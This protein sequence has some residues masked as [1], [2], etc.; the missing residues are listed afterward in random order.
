MMEISSKPS[1]MRTFSFGKYNGKTVEE[2]AKIDPSYLKWFLDTK[3]KD[4]GDD[5]DW[6]Y[7]LKYYLEK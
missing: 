4:G 2:V 5:E 7:T 6:I 3:E 1:L